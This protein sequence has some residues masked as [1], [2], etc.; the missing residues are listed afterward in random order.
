M[1]RQKWIKKKTERIAETE[2]GK[3]QGRSKR[4]AEAREFI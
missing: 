1:L 3:E 4:N 2:D